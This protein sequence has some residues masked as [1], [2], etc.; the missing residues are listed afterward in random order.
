MTTRCSRTAFLGGAV[1]HLLVPDRPVA[2][3]AVIGVIGKAGQIEPAFAD[4]G[5]QPLDAVV[6]GVAKYKVATAADLVALW[7]NG[8]ITVDRGQKE[9]SAA[10]PAPAA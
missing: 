10:L 4:V 5:L 7:H 2:I 6:L 9:V 3:G 8:R 1:G